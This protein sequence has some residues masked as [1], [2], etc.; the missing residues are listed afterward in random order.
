[1]CWPGAV[2]YSAKTTPTHSGRSANL[3]GSLY[4]LGEYQAARELDEDVLARRCR[5]LGEDHPDTLGSVSNLAG[6]LHAVCEYQA[7]RKLY[8]DV[9]ARRCR[10]LGEDHP[11]TLWSANGLPPAAC[12]CW[13]SI[14]RRGTFFRMPGPAVPCAR[15]G[16]P[17]HTRVGQ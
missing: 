1:M 5:V 14:R 17:R 12:T 4:A 8:E 9:L 11:D 7:A 13:A 15:R 6:S 2:A 3:A 16:P 10:L